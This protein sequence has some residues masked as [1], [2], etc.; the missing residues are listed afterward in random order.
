MYIRV[1]Q[2]IP[3]ARIDQLK[4]ET[5]ELQSKV[6]EKNEQRNLNLKLDVGKGETLSAADQVKQKIAA[7]SS[8]FGKFVSGT[9]DKRK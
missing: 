2:C 3:N 5:T 9:V 6:K 8:T 7:K 1:S 4:K